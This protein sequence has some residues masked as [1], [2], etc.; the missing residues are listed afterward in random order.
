MDRP[1]ERWEPDRAASTDTVP[2]PPLTT[3]LKR[4]ALNRCPFCGEGKVFRGYLTV[5]PECS[6]CGA[7]LGR[8]R[9][10]DAPPYFTIFIVGHLFVPVVFWVEKA[11]EPPMWLHM[12]LWLPLF[13]IASM[14]TLRPVKGAVVGWML[15][16]GLTGNEGDAPVVRRRDGTAK[17]VVVN[18]SVQRGDG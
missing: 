6:H 16:L 15:R 18:P 1:P 3:M 11:Y 7:E 13:T 10:D 12:A 9:A 2:L 8:L 4:G 5:V 14:L 17:P